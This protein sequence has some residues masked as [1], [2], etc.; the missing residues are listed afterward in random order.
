MY[1]RRLRCHP[2]L[3]N[4]AAE[5]LAQPRCRHPPLQQQAGTGYARHLPQH[6]R[7][8]PAGQTGASG[9]GADYAGI[10]PPLPLAF[11][12]G[13]GCLRT[14]QLRQKPEHELQCQQPHQ[15]LLSRPHVQRPHPRTGTGGY[16][17]VYRQI[18]T[19][20]CLKGRLKISDDLSNKSCYDACVPACHE[21]D[22]QPTIAKSHRDRRC[23]NELLKKSKPYKS[24]IGRLK[25]RNAFSD[26]PSPPHHERNSC[27]PNKS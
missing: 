6:R 16:R 13:I 4:H 27:P 18:L 22:P 24:M 10:R 5:I 23:G 14:L 1:R 8:R 19:G 15:P 21:N 3:S 25:T 9:L 26:D 7:Y 12:L 20:Q 2:F 17:R 11:R